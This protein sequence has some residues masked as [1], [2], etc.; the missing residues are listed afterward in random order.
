MNIFL[1]VQRY[2]LDICLMSPALRCSL[3]PMSGINDVLGSLLGKI[4]TL[5]TSFA[6]VL[7]P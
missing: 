4:V 1:P 2:I 5:L 6:N 3:C 7:F